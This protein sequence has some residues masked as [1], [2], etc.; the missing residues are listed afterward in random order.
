[1]CLGLWSS[2]IMLCPLSMVTVSHLV[3]CHL[4]PSFS[5]LLAQKGVLHWASWKNG[6]AWR[7]VMA[8]EL[9]E[10]RFLSL[11]HLGS[12]LSCL[13]EGS[14]QWWHFQWPFF[15][16]VFEEEWIKSID[17][18]KGFEPKTLPNHCGEHTVCSLVI[19]ASKGVLE[20]GQLADRFLNEWGIFQFICGEFSPTL[21][22]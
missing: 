22:H 9:I 14:F 12:I 16:R 10:G 6:Q 13:L 21:Q 20:T 18:G 19:W 2:E 3:S 17:R 7:G 11:T 1:M 4:L 5:S 15:F 8:S